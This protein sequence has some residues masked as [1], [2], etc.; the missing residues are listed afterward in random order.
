MEISGMDPRVAQEL[1]PQLE[2]LEAHLTR[3]VIELRRRTD[4]ALRE[5]RKLKEAT[6]NVRAQTRPSTVIPQL[7][8]AVNPPRI[9]VEFYP[10]Q[11]LRE[12]LQAW[13]FHWPEGVRRP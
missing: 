9:H 4:D 7:I 11:T 5:L 13:G 2:A 10:R 3:G 8:Q 1:L 6:Q 12:Y